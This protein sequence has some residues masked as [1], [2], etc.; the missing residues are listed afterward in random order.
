MIEGVLYKKGK[1]K[2]SWKKYYFKLIGDQL[3]KIKE[4]SMKFKA[5]ECIKNYRIEKYVKIVIEEHSYYGFRLI[6]N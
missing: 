3:F 4:D 6:K 1:K 5:C 2:N